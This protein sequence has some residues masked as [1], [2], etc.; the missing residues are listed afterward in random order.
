VIIDYAHSPR[1]LKLALCDIRHQFGLPI[2]CVFGCGGDRDRKK[3]PLMMQEALKGAETIVLTS[4]NPRSEDPLK[5]I[6]DIKVALTTQDHKRV[7]VYVH[8][9]EAVEYAL[10]MAI[11]DYQGQVSVLVAGKGVEDRQII[12]DVS[13]PFSDRNVV[14]EFFM[15]DTSG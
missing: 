9:R 13:V 7:Y 1:A 10:K 5:I 3:R 14:E 6:E 11:K 4:D 15:K 2:I 8:R 12:G